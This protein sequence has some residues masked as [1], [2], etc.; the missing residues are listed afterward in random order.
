MFDDRKQNAYAFLLELA[1]QKGYVT[2]DNI[3]AASEQC[4]LSIAEVDW[5]SNSIAIR[6]III[7]DKEPEEI[8]HVNEEDEYDDYAQCDYEAIYDKAKE[9]APSLISF[10]DKVRSIRPPQWKELSSLIYQAKE[11]NEFARNR[12]IEM[13]LRLAVRLGVQR[14]E[15][16]DADLADCIGDA[17]V[18]LLIAV[19]RYDPII[20]GP[21]ASYASLWIFQNMSKEQ[22]NQRPL[23]RYPLN[24]RTQ[25]FT[26]FPILKARGCVECDKIMSCARVREIIETKLECSDRDIEEV[27]LQS[28][29][30]ESYD[31]ISEK[32]FDEGAI[33]Y[34][35][36]SFRYLLEKLTK[37]VDL[38][39]RID[40]K[41]LRKVIR[42]LVKS[43]HGREKRVIIGRFG[44]LDGKEKTL[45]ALA[46][47]FGITRERVRQIEARALKRLRKPANMKKLE[48]FI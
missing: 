39:L 47:D 6:G 15:Q 9:L 23:I 42:F 46:Q 11:G 29:P 38:D 8:N 27:I 10:I 33:F 22:G 48:G 31:A 1:A 32:V 25:Y 43:L 35:N 13:H 12:I 3:I 21:F 16:Y 34:E 37:T 40:R 44:L 18:G 5:L 19:D 36:Y 14:A 28:V 2:F 24:R 17:C 7:Y 41:R 30:L 26:M 20:N 4:Q 45:E